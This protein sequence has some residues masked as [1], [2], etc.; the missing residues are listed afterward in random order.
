MNTTKF[1]DKLL[2]DSSSEEP[3]DLIELEMQSEDNS[4]IDGSLTNELVKTQAGTVLKKFS[5]R[6]SMAYVQMLGRIPAFKLEFQR[7]QDRIE[8]ERKFREFISDYGIEMPEILG[9]SEEYAEFKF[10]EGDDLNDYINENP[11]EASD[12]GAEVGEFL[13]YVHGNDGAIT[14]L[15]ANNFMVLESG[16]PAFL[17]AEYFTDDANSW[18][19]EMDLITLVSSLKQVEPKPY[20]S[21]RE[22][23]ESSYKG[24]VDMFADIASSATSQIHARYLEKNS[25]RAVNAK[26][27]TFFSYL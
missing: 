21:F 13:N 16:E 20:R 10:L 18:E 12:L 26:E 5:R 4:S 24:E 3:E 8:N 6:P 22:G 9:V 25:D 23:F 19:K 15:R 17:D 27:N 2:S 14:D 11:G 1:Y 7:Q